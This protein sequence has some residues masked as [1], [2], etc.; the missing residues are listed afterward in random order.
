MTDRKLVNRKEA[1]IQ[2]LLTARSIE[3]AARI[4]SVPLRTLRRWLKEPEFAAAYREAQREV[5]AQQTARMQQMCGAAVTTLGKIMVDPAAPASTRVRA[6]QA[7]LEGTARAIEHEDV[8]ARLAAL[9]RAAE[10][11]QE[12]TW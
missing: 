3:D 5:Y 9:E 8:E 4:A 10:Q 1:A 2:A 6:A 11:S 7:I 12:R